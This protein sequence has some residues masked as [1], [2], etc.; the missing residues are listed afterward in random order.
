MEPTDLDQKYSRLME[1]ARQARE[2]FD[3]YQRGMA[4]LEEAV[5]S[6]AAPVTIV[7][8]EGG[9]VAGVRIADIW[10]AQVGAEAVAAELGSALEKVLLRGLAP[11][12]GLVYEALGLYLAG[13]SASHV[14]DRIKTVLADPNGPPVTLIHFPEL[15]VLVQLGRVTGVTFDT[16]WYARADVSEVEDVVKQRINAVLERDESE[17]GSD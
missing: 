17:G 9:L 13:A 4:E 2:R 10:F 12:E 11:D 7:E 16:D 5:A 14:A 8:G 3:E 1:R 15:A 6:R